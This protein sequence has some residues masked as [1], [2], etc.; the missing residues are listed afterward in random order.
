M[1]ELKMDKMTTENCSMKFPIFHSLLLF[2][3]TGFTCCTGSAGFV[4]GQGVAATP[5]PTKSREFSIP[6]TVRVGDSADPVKEVELLYSQDRGVRWYSADR[7]PVEAG[8]FTYKTESDGEYW[9]AFR[10]VTL[11]G[12]VKQAGITSQIRVL[13]DS[14]PPTLSFS[15]TQQDSGNLLV[16]W[17]AQDRNF[18]VKSPDFAVSVPTAPEN[19]KHWTPINFDKRNVRITES[20]L[21]GRFVF[22]PESGVAKIEIRASISDIAGNRIEK[23]IP[24]TMKPVR[25]DAVLTPDA[26][27]A[28]ATVA[29]I[30]SANSKKTPAGNSPTGNIETITL[31]NGSV[32]VVP[33]KP[34]RV[35]R[36]TKGSAQKPELSKTEPSKA[37]P[38]K[39]DAAKTDLPDKP[40]PDIPVIIQEADSS[41][42]DAT[43]TQQPFPILLSPDGKYA[44]E[45]VGE[46]TPVLVENKLAEALLANMGIFFD[47][48]LPAK[49]SPIVV[50][51]D[52]TVSET[53]VSETETPVGVKPLV[54]GNIMGI[55][56]NTSGKQPQ[57]F[58][59]WNVGDALWNNAQIDIFRS[60]TVTG[61][62]QPIAI[63]LRNSGEYWWFLTQ[64]DLK[65]FYIMVRIR[66][67]HG[68]V[69]NDIT[70]TP[71]E[72]NPK[73]LSR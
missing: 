30:S 41:K 18:Q 11:S 60:V 20:E 51:P 16:V 17:T 65:P 19:E 47:G 46:V 10:T 69:G 8:K 73:F 26:P 2:C 49:A 32:S 48:S 58:V 15:V 6:F 33:P 31:P 39:T 27:V 13:I 29:I 63:N 56:L 12:V 71:I 67:L 54:A 53:T 62:W 37:K 45:A 42:A 66:S 7:R 22:L 9:F 59:K 23:I 14:T 21:E 40:E 72:I 55:T 34:V 70:Q 44:A 1:K 61:V 68:G 50:K 35:H 25:H 24:V 4:H 28:N 3:F 36:Q 5:I 64:E 43:E 57:I 52:Q 38:P